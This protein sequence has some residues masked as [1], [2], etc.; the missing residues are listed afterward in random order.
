MR[1]W[2]AR[3]AILLG[4][5]SAPAFG[6][7]QTGSPP[8]LQPVAPQIAPL[9]M[10]SLAGRPPLYVGLSD[11]PAMLFL[12]NRT[13]TELQLRKL[14]GQSEIQDVFHNAD[15]QN[16][17]LAL[18]RA[19]SGG[20]IDAWQV[21]QLAHLQER[22]ALVDRLNA[23]DWLEKY[24]AFDLSAAL[25][26][27]SSACLACLGTIEFPVVVPADFVAA[28]FA[29]IGPAELQKDSAFQTLAKDKLTA[30]VKGWIDAVNA[31]G[32]A[33]HIV[34]YG[35]VDE[36]SLGLRYAITF[37]LLIPSQDWR[38][39]DDGWDHFEITAGF[40][41]SPAASTKITDV[42]V[43]ADDYQRIGGPDGVPD[44]QSEYDHNIR[45]ETRRNRE[46]SFVSAIHSAAN[47]A[48]LA[49]YALVA[50]DNTTIATDAQTICN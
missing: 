41:P 28:G 12:G 21:P 47:D 36:T 4:A 40:V 46:A 18:Q 16:A 14:L 1:S 22:S 33:H 49:G 19:L 11:D 8:L 37:R 3:L 5:I 42:L 50:S 24:R 17:I 7:D 31:T 43:V 10:G 44:F 29:D 2:I 45:T 25:L 34:V 48:I 30:L 20:A 9:D 13:D 39:D 38:T 23:F 15:R 35:P 26:A 27:R 32:G 6:Q